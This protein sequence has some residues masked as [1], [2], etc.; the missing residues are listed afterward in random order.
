[1]HIKKFEAPTLQEALENVK[2]DLGPEAI[3]LQTKKHK[4]GFG[5]MSKASVE[6]TAAVSDRSLL[7]R[8]VTERKLGKN[9][10]EKMQT[11]PASKQAELQDRIHDEVMDSHLAAAMN[12]GKKDEVRI[13]RQVDS[14]APHSAGRATRAMPATSSE[15]GALYARPNRASVAASPSAMASPSAA[16]PHSGSLPRTERRY[17]DITDD[18]EPLN[19]ISKGRAMGQGLSGNKTPV[20]SASVTGATVKS[21]TVMVQAGQISSGT[22][23]AGNFSAQQ[24]TS[25]TEIEQLKRMV[26]ELKT[27][28]EE[29]SVFAATDGARG[30]ARAEGITS[31]VL[32]EA[33]ELL[34]LNGLEKRY[35][36]QLIRKVAFELSGAIQDADQVLDQIAEEI[37]QTVRVLDLPFR[38]N[39]TGRPEVICVVGPTGVGK[40]T[41]VAKLAALALATKS[42]G[43]SLKVGLVN[44]DAYKVAAN[45]QLSTYARVLNVPFRAASN[46]DQLRAA[47]S[48]FENLD[49]VILDTAGRSHRDPAAL[50]EMKQ[51][52]QAIPGV[53][54]QLV[55]SATTR[56]TEL[57]DTVARFSIFPPEGISVA[58]LDEATTYGC[59]YNIA[60]RSKL[61]FVFFA[62]GQRV[63]E[64]IEAATSERV[65]A[66]VLDLE[67]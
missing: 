15:A 42:N 4:R 66:L 58:K 53:R 57:A 5:L 47:L 21:T 11:L 33:F 25:S 59:L 46:A 49:L 65:A 22:P 6:I 56:D 64:D 41:T 50:S 19:D 7:K 10:V 12:Q 2:R 16:A 38:K 35:A 62:T 61:P 40:T 14:A 1:M 29:Q 31:P 9:G 32:Q 23:G 55:L 13:Q 18:D 44:L 45:D 67:F 34:I 52:I 26:M 63:P 39:I 17:I 54:T 36:V 37:L 3:I 30:T 51:L 60:S 43:E 20:S 28:Q 27:A 24:G 48:D 8:A